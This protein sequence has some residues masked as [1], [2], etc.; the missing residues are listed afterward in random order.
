[1]C[2]RVSGSSQARYVNIATDHVLSH[3]I[4]CTGFEQR[5]VLLLREV[6][7]SLMLNIKHNRVEI[8]N[9]SNNVN[10]LVI[11]IF[12]IVY[13]CFSLLILNKNL[14]QNRT[15]LA[16]HENAIFVIIILMI[17]KMYT[18]IRRNKACSNNKC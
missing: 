9:A 16:S 13:T 6:F 10:C 4:V 17:L 5:R 14:K 8:E 3:A 11:L 1:M 18:H 7:S 2:P 15:E 12:V